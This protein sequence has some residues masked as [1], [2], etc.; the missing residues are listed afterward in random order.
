MGRRGPFSR[1]DWLCDL[2]LLKFHCFHFQV[3]RM[4]EELL[5]RATGRLMGVSYVNCPTQH[6]CV[7]TCTINVHSYLSSPS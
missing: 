1:P 2:N 4:E 6:L 5:Y 7:V 3:Y